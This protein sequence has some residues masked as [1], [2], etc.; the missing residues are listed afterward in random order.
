MSR[1]LTPEQI[2]RYSRQ[3]ILPGVG[4][5]GQLRLAESSA[6]V[7]GAGG[8]GSPVLLYLAAA[9]VGRIGVVDPDRVELSNLGRQVLYTTADIGRP[10]A[11]TA[12]ERLR[13]LNPD[14]ETV[15][16]QAQ[17]QAENLPSLAA[18]YDVLIDASDSFAVKF[19][20]NDVAVASHRPCVIA[21]VL[22]FAG[23][24]MSVIPGQTPCFRCLFEE[25]P[26]PEA[27]QSCQEAGV[28]GALVGVV[29][30][31]QAAETLRILLRLDGS[32]PGGL[33]QI[34]VITGTFRRLVFETRSDCAAC[35][36]TL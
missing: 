8:L 25:Q 35:A 30:S 5:R 32:R 36:G 16:L 2:L 11:T 21:S 29:G 22:A 10:K 14:V 23:Q 3:L 1:E 34:D 28:L 9:G 24:V 7:V 27:V 19:A 13:Q 18:G 4:A 31:L 15:P 12:A 33:L 20:V 26:P 6:L 17:I